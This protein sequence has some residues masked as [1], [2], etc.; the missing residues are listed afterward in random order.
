MQAHSQTRILVAKLP[1]YQW[2]TYRYVASKLLCHGMQLVHLYDV[3]GYRTE[4]ASGFVPRFAVYRLIET[5]RLYILGLSVT[6]TFT[7]LL[8]ISGCVNVW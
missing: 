5:L 2:M 1:Y 7:R 6:T 3:I 4:P 8:R